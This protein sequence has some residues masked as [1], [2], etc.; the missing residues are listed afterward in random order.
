MGM[1]FW[2]MLDSAGQPEAAVFASIDDAKTRD[3]RNDPASYSFVEVEATG[4]F[5]TIPALLAAGLE[6]LLGDMLADSL[7]YTDTAGGPAP[8]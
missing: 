7:R 2:T 6:P 8:N 3:Q 5:A 1:G 4:H